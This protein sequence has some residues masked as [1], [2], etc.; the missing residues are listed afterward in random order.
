MQQDAAHQDCIPM[1]RMGTRLNEG[2]TMLNPDI[3]GMSF[4]TSSPPFFKEG[5]GV[6]ALVPMGAWGPG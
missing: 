4:R 2:E 3:V 5:L 6:V 1:R